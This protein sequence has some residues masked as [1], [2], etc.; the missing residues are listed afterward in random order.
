MIINGCA[1]SF[2]LSLSISITIFRPSCSTLGAS[3]SK[4]STITGYLL[5]VLLN[6]NKC[7]HAKTLHDHCLSFARPAQTLGAS[8]PKVSNTTV[9]PFQSIA[10]SHIRSLRRNEC[11]RTSLDGE[12]QGH[13]L[14]LTVLPHALACDI[15]T[16]LQH[17]K[18]ETTG[19]QRLRQTARA[20][21]CLQHCPFL[22]RW[23]AM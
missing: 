23:R 2:S 11:K 4:L 10:Q 17:A 6:T 9:Y 15:A 16:L 14:A 3:M 20:R 8:M 12:R 22:Q 19:R 7:L 5:P 18:A 1:S 21:L 13:S